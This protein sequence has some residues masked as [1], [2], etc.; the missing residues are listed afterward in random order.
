MTEEEKINIKEQFNYIV[1]DGIAPILKSAGFR[2]KGNNFHAHVRELDWCI[3]IQKDG[4]GFDRYFNQWGFTINIGVTWSDYAI[5]LF[6]KVSDFPLEGY[7]PIRARIG[8]IMGKGDY[9]FK[10][11]PHQD[12]SPV[13][14]LI[15][16]TIKEKVL[17]LLNDIKCLNDLWNFIEDNRPWHTFLIKL[18]HVKSKQ[19]VFSVTPIDLYV[20][21]LATG[22]TK[23]AKLLRRKMERRRRK[24]NDS[25][26]DKIVE[27]YGK[28][29]PETDRFL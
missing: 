19:K 26:L 22:K 12:C 11:R 8:T 17:P 5:C 2:K 3:N 7:C 28:R 21:C 25:L 29:S 9:W 13:K 14:D 23:K 4:W 18:F 10:L 16:S 6:N 1:K 20:L 15:C 27:T 24:V